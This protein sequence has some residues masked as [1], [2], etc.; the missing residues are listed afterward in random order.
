MSAHPDLQPEDAKAMVNYVLSLDEGEDDGEGGGAA[1]SL[2]EIPDNQWLKAD[3]T[4]GDRDLSPGLFVKLWPSPK[5]MR[6]LADADFTAKP[7]V[8][9]S[10][11][12]VEAGGEDFGDF[13]DNFYL[14]ATGYL[15]L[16][17][18]DNV[19]FQLGSDDG[20]R[21]WVDGQEIIDNDG[22][23]GMSPKEAEIALRAGYH[24]IRLDYFQG[25]GGRGIVLK[26]ARFG[27]E[28]GFKVISEGSFFHK[29]SDNVEGMGSMSKTETAVPG[30]GGGIEGSTPGVRPHA[31]AARRVFTQ[32]S[33]YGF[34][35]GWTYGSL[36]LGCLWR[37][38]HFGKRTKWRPQTDKS[39]K[40]CCRTCRA[41]GP[42]SGRRR[43]FRAS[44]TGIDQARGHQ[45][46]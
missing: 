32:G 12:K 16:E 20:S 31:G 19:V 22:P 13:K 15:F 4:V 21:L 14:Q 38:V 17:K 9:A 18:D 24:P 27:A 28:P 37:S 36:D 46:R 41:F 30:D 26:W 1:K 44:K 33:G 3:N 8:V 29:K 34:S 43:D 10:A 7:A 45:R 5:S 6:L 11:S 23:H 40:D 42:E 39:K 25:G 35:A 2:A